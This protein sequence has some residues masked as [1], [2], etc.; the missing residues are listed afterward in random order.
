MKKGAL[1]SEGE[2]PFG[3]R[4]FS[5]INSSQEGKEKSRVS[6][7]GPGGGRNPTASENAWNGGEGATVM[8][9]SQVH[10]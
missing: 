1:E 3:N 2:F 5:I 6:F 8:F 7:W 4:I 9:G 10:M